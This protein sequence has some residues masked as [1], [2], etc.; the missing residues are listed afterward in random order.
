MSGCTLGC[1]SLLVLLYT[2]CG[3]GMLQI[4]FD[5]TVPLG[6]CAAFWMV[7]PVRGRHAQ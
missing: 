7:W 5:C 1:T 6:Y 4:D 3:I 2:Y